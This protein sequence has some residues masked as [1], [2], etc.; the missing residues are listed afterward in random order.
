[1]RWGVFTT[2]VGLL[3][4][5]SGAAAENLPVTYTVNQQI[6]K[7]DAA[8]GTLLTFELHGD[9][10]CSSSVHT[11]TLPLQDPA[12]LIEQI[13]LMR[14]R[15]GARPPK[16]AR[17]RF[18]LAGVTAAPPLFLRVSGAGI[19]P[20]G[21]ECQPQAATATGGGVSGLSCWDLDADGSCDLG[22]PDED[23]DDDGSC[24][25]LDCRG[26][27]GPA[28]QDG[29]NGTAI[30][31]VSVAGNDV[32]FDG[33]NVHIRDGSG[34]THGPTNGL[35]NVIIGYNED[36]L[37]AHDRT[38]SHNLVVG[39]EHTYSSY[40]GLVAGVQ[41]TIIAPNASV[42][43][44]WQNVASGDTASVSG[45]YR[46]EASGRSASVSGGG[47]N[48]AS[49]IE[50]SV[51]GGLFNTASGNSASVSGGHNNTASGERASVSGGEYN[52]AAGAF[53]SVR[54]GG[55]N[56]ALNMWAW[57]GGGGENVAQGTF[58]S[59][60]GGGLNRANSTRASITG[61]WQNTAT[62]DYAAVGGGVYNL[63][64]GNIS[65]VCGGIR[66]TASGIESS[67]GGGESN[68][69]SGT[70]ASVGGGQRN[71]ASGTAQFL[72]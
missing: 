29:A 69:A 9:S 24:T 55:G 53:A 15:G 42:S 19:S 11:E 12:L 43:G 48:T 5:A 3:F 28:G 41:N 20:I 31:C 4:P 17:F 67:V 22:S 14:V 1:M 46:N 70:W 8:A 30:P 52:V 38:G 36:A 27:Q 32:F 21:G 72:P 23:M 6:L 35:G 44:G 49:L 45:G 16:V 59:V 68:E 39:P 61:G 60:S 63:A 56:Q 7:R 50:S 33:C 25:A 37:G 58:S 64:G 51:S 65:A 57:V 62:G 26:A 47:G 13:R 10:A 54:G 34:D 40:G 18:V 66:N 2:V 71:V